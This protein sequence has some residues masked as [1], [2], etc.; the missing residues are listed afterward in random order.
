MA[1]LQGAPRNTQPSPAG[2]KRNRLLK[3]RIFG[4]WPRLANG[5][6][7]RAAGAWPTGRRPCRAAES[8]RGLMPATA[9][10]PGGAVGGHGRGELFP[11]VS[12]H[13]R[14]AAAARPA[15]SPLPDALERIEAFIGTCWDAG[16]EIGSSVRT[17]DDCLA[18]NPPPTSRCRPHCWRRLRHRRPRCSPSFPRTLARA[19]PAALSSWPRRWR[20][21]SATKYE[22]TPYALEPNCKESPGGLRDLHGHP[23]VARAAGWATVGWDELARSRPGHALRG[24]PDQAQRRAAELH[25]RP[26][27]PAGR[28]ARGP[29]G[30]RPPDRR[31]RKLRL[32]ATRRRRRPGRASE[33]TDAPLLLGRQGGDP[34]Q[35]DPAAQNIEGG[36]PSAAGPAAPV[37]ERFSTRP[38]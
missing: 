37:N 17:V 25:P 27:A 32:R 18:Q 38:A 21:A 7:A 23:G 12:R 29:A 22:N 30:V 8:A 13:R 34:A 10:S 3:A 31:G 36:S 1:V 35:P 26:A 11:L 2:S 4:R 19:G 6:S 24:A 5:A 33:G 20:C 16:L 28:P 15:G 9:L 14:G